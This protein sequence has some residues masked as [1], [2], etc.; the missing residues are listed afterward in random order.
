MTNERPNGTDYLNEYPSTRDWAELWPRVVGARAAFTAELTGV[1]EQQAAWRPPSGDG[2]A[3]WSIIEVARHVLTYTANVAAIVEATAS[4][5]TVT[6][7]PAGALRDDGRES[8]SDLLK[9]LVAVSTA[10]AGLA[11]SLPAP[12]N[13]E[14]TVSHA[15]F[16]PLNC[17][18]WFLFPSIHAADHTQHIQALKEMSGFPD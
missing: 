14:T 15:R 8:L 16:G 1:S 4:G 3:G 12:S 2:E 18:S 10:F 9:E 11:N 7:D 13:L 17:K 5:S 6:K